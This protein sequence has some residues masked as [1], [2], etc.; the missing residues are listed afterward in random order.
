[1]FD[2]IIAAL[3]SLVNPDMSKEEVAAALDK[4][5]N[6]LAW[7]TSTVD[8]L[9]VLKL[10]PSL[11]ARQKMAHKL[12]HAEFKGSDSDNTWLHTK[13]LE[14]VSNHGIKVQ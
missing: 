3:R 11:E 1:M 2:K 10:D 4:H 13:V 8:L 14:E 7:R 12:G 5:A 9:K 6:G